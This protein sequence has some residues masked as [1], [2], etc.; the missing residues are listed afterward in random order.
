MMT[1]NR[2]NPSS[3][4]RAA[5]VLG[6]VAFAAGLLALS[7]AAEAQSA[8]TLMVRGGVT[9]INPDVDSGD[10]SPPAFVGTKADIKGD[11]Q[12]GGGIS[13]M[14]TDNFSIDFPLATPFKHEID[15]AGAIAGVGKIGE[16]HALPVTLLAQWRF[17]DARAPFRP[18]VGAGLTYAKFYKAKS[19]AVFS[20]MTGGTPAN[21]TT[22]SVDSKFAATIEAGGTYSFTDHW[23]IEG[24]VAHTFLKT[25]TTLSS[26]Q[27]LDAKIDPNTYSLAVGYAF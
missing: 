10:L 26:G 17:L 18:Y 20:A 14:L 3:S 7:S 1:L 25:R 21:P 13:Y 4:S 22:L 9:R 6:A 2:S 27:T 24:F 5:S 16:V 15:G 11:T 23:F 12:F 19:T 8:G